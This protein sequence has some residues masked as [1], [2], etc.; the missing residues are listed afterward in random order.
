MVRVLAAVLLAV[1]L[2]ACDS[3]ASGGEDYTLEHKV[4]IIDADGFVPE[5]HVTVDRARYLLDQLH[6]MTGYPRL[7]IADQAAK[8]RN[9][10]RERYGREVSL[11]ELLEAANQSEAIAV[12]GARL[13]DFYALYVALAGR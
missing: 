4:A 6:Q 3:Q 2:A 9:V 8:A 12:D 1:L 10:L 7:T 11:L 5:S 13:E